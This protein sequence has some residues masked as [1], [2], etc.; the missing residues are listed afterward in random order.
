MR[1]LG[2]GLGINRGKA[3]PTS[4]AVNTVAPTLSA[5]P[6]EAGQTA[7]ITDG[8]WSNAVSYQYRVLRNGDVV[9]GRTASTFTI[10]EEDEATDLVAQVRANDALG[11]WS[12]WVS[13]NTMSVPAV[14]PSVFTVGMWTL[15]DPSS[16]NGDQLTVTISSLPDTGTGP[17]TAIQYDYDTGS[18]YGAKATL[19]ATTTGIYTI[20][21][22]PAVTLTSVRLYAV[23]A[24][25]SSAASDVK[26]ATPTSPFANVAPDVT[27]AAF[28]TASSPNV[29]SFNSNEAGTLFYATN[30]SATPLSGSDIEA[31]VTAA[32]PDL[33]GSFIVDPGDNSLNINPA[34]LAVG[35]HYLHITVKDEGGLYSTDDVVTIVV[36]APAISSTSPADNATGVAINVSPTITFNGPIAFG[37]GNIVL[38]ENNGGWADLETFDVATEQGTGAGQVSISGS[39]LT[40][41]P[42]A[43]LTNS[44]EYAIRIAST[45]ID[46]IFGNSFSG[47]A[48]DTTISFTTVAASAGFTLVGTTT[49]TGVGDKSLTALTGGVASS[50]AEGDI[51]IVAYATGSA[52]DPVMEIK[53]ASGGTDYTLIGS[54]LYSNDSNDSGLRVAYKV[55]GPTPD[56]SVYVSDGSATGRACAI[57]VWRGQSATPID[58][59]PTTATGID[60]TA[61]D[62]A[63]ITPATSG[64]K[65]FVVGAYAHQ[66]GTVAITQ[67]YLNDATSAT[68][69]GSGR[70]VSLVMGSVD[71]TSGEYNPA[72]MTVTGATTSD[73][74]TA[75]TFALR[76]A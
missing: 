66:L 72:T 8:T 47:V 19:S 11:V 62:P 54:E 38:R 76:P 25:G 22:S 9:D 48:D 41:N 23:N 61:I 69:N 26:S 24:H 1:K 67:S 34:P 64:A 42:T 31:L 35:T 29:L 20:T 57:Q 68:F 51:V 58:V 53:D 18:G 7:T 10:A 27:D 70:D 71:W 50:P 12:A 3:A 55:M 63:A 33:Y 15:T 46:D 14:L 13:S 28:S 16:D 32:T 2:L 5:T 17:L 44:R 59:T 36:S 65:I 37:T 74:W 45:A 49:G 75:V 39:T 30:G 52:G 21:V 4:L 56:T 6:V 43:D 40:I 73:S 60:G